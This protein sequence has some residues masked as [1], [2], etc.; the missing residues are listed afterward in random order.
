[1]NSPQSSCYDFASLFSQIT[2]A[3]AP[4]NASSRIDATVAARQVPLTCAVYSIVPA[5][6]PATAPPIC[7]ATLIV[8]DGR[9]SL[10]RCWLPTASSLLTSIASLTHSTAMASGR[11]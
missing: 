3:T 7:A 10:M 4:P 2:I 9:Y 1:M 8:I 5:N 11:K 6:V